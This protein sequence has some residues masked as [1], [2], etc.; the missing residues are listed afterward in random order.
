MVAVLLKCS[1]HKLSSVRVLFTFI[2]S[3][4]AI[5]P[6][7]QILLSMDK[8]KHD[9]ILIIFCYDA[10]FPPPIVFTCQIKLCQRRVILQNLTQ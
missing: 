10:F 1:P 4:S 9:V 8:V 7:S 6:L 5:T 3:L 2:A